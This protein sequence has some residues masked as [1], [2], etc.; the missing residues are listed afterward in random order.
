MAEFHFEVAFVNRLLKYLTFWVNPFLFFLNS[1]YPDNW[2]GKK[3]HS[4]F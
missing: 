3:L 2:T 4:S 1:D